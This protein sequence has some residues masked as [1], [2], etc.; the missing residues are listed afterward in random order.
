LDKAREG[1]SEHPQIQPALPTSAN[2]GQL[3]A[4]LLLVVS[5]ATGIG[6]S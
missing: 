1:P 4:L 5:V 6:P 3:L 2:K